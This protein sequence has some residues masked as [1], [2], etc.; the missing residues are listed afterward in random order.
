MTIRAG[1]GGTDAQDWS[2]M[3]M[4]MYLGWARSR[5][6]EA[7]IQ[8][9]AYG[10]RAGIRT[11]TLRIAGPGAYADMMEETEVHRLVRRS[12]YDT[13]GRRQTSFASVETVPEPPERG[14][15][16]ISQEDLR[17]DTFRSSGPGGQHVQK[18]ESAV[19][20]T[21]IPTGIKAI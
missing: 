19:R 4:E 18:V 3:L 2:R 5:G 12:P 14:R 9:T 13:A 1:A 21:H 11:A 7:E 20:I 8:D 17:I 6:M 15:V 10:D 16:Q